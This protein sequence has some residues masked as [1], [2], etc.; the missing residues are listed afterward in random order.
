MDSAT[1]HTGYGNQASVI[2]PI[3]VKRGWDVYQIACNCWGLENQIKESEDG[4]HYYKGVKLIKNPDLGT[5]SDGGIYPSKE[6]VKKIYDK[7]KPDIIF[8]L[9]DFYRVAS[10]LE[11]GEEFK[12]KWVHWLP[13]DNPYCS[14]DWLHLEKQMKYLMFLSSFGYY[15]RVEDLD[16]V[17]YVDAIYH[18]I[19]SEDFRPLDKEK[20]KEAHGLKNKFVIVTVGRHQPR[21]MIYHTANAVGRFLQNNKDAVWI[22]KTDPRDRA[23]E[24]SKE[25]ERDLEKLMNGYGVMDRVLFVPNALPTD[26]LNDL[27]NTGD[28][29]IHLSGGEG[30]G[31]PYVESMLAGTPCILNDNT[32]SPELTGGWKFGLPV[33]IQEKR[34][35][36]GFNCNFDIGNLDEA[37]EQL[38]F[39]YNDWKNGGKWLKT[40]SK[41]GRDFHK[42]W[43]DAD[44]VTT[45]IEETF[46]R[47]VRYNNKVIWYSI[48]GTG[49]GYA[50]LSEYMLPALEELGYDVYINDWWGNQSPILTDYVKNLYQKTLKN[51]QKVNFNDVPQIL[52]WGFTSYPNLK[53]KY[54]LG[55]PFVES[56]K[57]RKFYADRVNMADFLLVSSDFT[58]NVLKDSGVNTEM[59]MV[60]PYIDIHKFK[61]IPRHRKE[62]DPFTFL[63]IGVMQER[64]NTHQCLDGYLAAFPDNGK[65]K[66][67]IKSGDFGDV[68]SLRPKC[69]GRKD[70]EIIFTDGMKPFPLEELMKLYERADCYVNISHGEGIGMPDLE[71]MATGLPVIGS[72]WDTR[73]L[74]IDDDVGYVVKLTGHV[75]AYRHSGIEEDC[76]VWAAFD[77]NDYVR[78]LKHVAEHKEEAREKGRKSAEKILNNFRSDQAAMDLDKV[79]MEIY[80]IKV[81][82]KWNDRDERTLNIKP[83]PITEKDKILIGIPSK[84]RAKSLSRLLD[85]LRNQTVSNFDVVIVDDSVKENY[86][87]EAELNAAINKLFDKGIYVLRQRGQGINQVAAHNDVIQQAMERGYKL[88][89]RLDDDIVLEPDNIE[90]IFNEFLKDEK[91]EYSAMG[92]VFL[93]PYN[94]ESKNHLPDNWRDIKELD[95][96][97]KTL[98]P[99]AQYYKYPDDVETRDDIEHLYSSF[100]FRPEL[101]FLVGG[102]PRDLS[103]VAFREETLP[104]YETKLQ[105]YKLKIVAKAIGY[106][107]HEMSGGCR[108]NNP[109]MA[110][111]MY[112]NDQRIFEEKIKELKKKYSKQANNKADPV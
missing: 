59:R 20:V 6:S 68:S 107:Y 93:N 14:K 61:Y 94:E 33:S 42:I 65:T 76:G 8:S 16:D 101:I 40:A 30:F 7:I 92:G 24:K 82:G 31:I 100:V 57:L 51:E 64:K 35:V 98:L 86:L 2:L 102:F 54:K 74:F 44:N 5:G 32:T 22:C 29:F 53:G 73:G 97:I 58:K 84:D 23:M 36:E 75:P 3:L 12:N 108:S 55:F 70:I 106:H 60:R 89:Y 27:Y 1:A 41:E 72:N 90:R 63:H 34:F 10:Y 45:K 77:G 112:R 39:V 21:K 71:A 91:C 99:T 83:M 110:E 13:I 48:F 43:C 28:I 85:S 78:I 81:N 95:G 25:E 103:N 46:Q 79:L 111:E 15:L 49:T 18:A 69:E 80:D 56:T 11:L 105:G 52:C 104:I 109:S 37:V 26:Q 9:N 96:S 66:L 19:S 50:A 88:V 87:Y 67:I 38:K 47:V 4:Y 62:S 17:R